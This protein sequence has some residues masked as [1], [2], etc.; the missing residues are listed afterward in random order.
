MKKEW[1]NVAAMLNA[2][3]QCFGGENEKHFPF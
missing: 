1:K 2:F 3:P